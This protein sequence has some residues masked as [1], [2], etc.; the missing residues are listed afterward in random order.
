M[1]SA[2]D[3][4][5]LL[6]RLSEALSDGLELEHVAT[7]VATTRGRFRRV[8]PGTGALPAELRPDVLGHPFPHAE[9][10]ALA[11]N[12]YA[13]R[14][15]LERPGTI[16][17]LIYLGLRRGIFPLGTEARE[18]V[19]SFAAQA[20]LGL[21]SSRR[22]DEL[23]RQAEEYR[24]LHAN[25]Q[26]II[27]SSA[28]AILVCDAH[29]RILS[30]NTR[31]AAVFDLERQALVGEPLGAFVRIPPQWA[32]QLPLRAVNAEAET[33]SQPPRSLLM[34]VSILELDSGSF[35][36]R[37]VVLQD[38][39]EMRELENRLLE[40]ERLAALGRLSAGLAHEINT[41]LT[42]IA[43]FAQMLG[44]MTPEQDPRS[45]L[46]S[47][48]VDQSFR[49]SRIVANLREAVRGSQ[50][51]RNVIDLGATAV[52][53]ARDA[54]RS[55][56]ATARLTVHDPPQPIMVW[57]ATGPVELA[58]GNL[59]RNAVEA[60]S[61]PSTVAVRIL[62]ADSWGVIEVEDEGPGVPAELLE[63]VFEPFYSTKTERGGTGLGLAISR[64]MITQL[65]GQV[66]LESRPEGGTRAVIRLQLWQ[67]TALSS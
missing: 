35:N 30:A 29:G 14:V 44:D 43:S 5:D 42:G 20:A 40:Q 8:T 64:D 46:V 61:D 4:D 31:A 47:K 13:L 49:V 16:H 67:P 56:G 33:T 26:R 41:P 27:E 51:D 6:E 59:V 1:A 22:L 21:E 36:G 60:S 58:V 9:E 17:G 10:Q 52:A 19:A 53:A 18:V 25:T 12:G 11:N 32:E 34:A 48:L 45:G 55:L 50:A 28:A 62:S 54:A 57:A 38:V 37:V 7:Y 63:K 39:T 66:A 3:P 23:R 65:G 24:I 15:P 2:T